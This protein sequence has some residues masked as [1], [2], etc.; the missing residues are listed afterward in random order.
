MKREDIDSLIELRNILIN[1]YSM[2]DNQGNP[3]T[4]VI[5]QRDVAKVIDRSMKKLDATLSRYVKI[6]S[7]K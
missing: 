4:A 3:G 1:G 2:L 6:E 7:K 5:L